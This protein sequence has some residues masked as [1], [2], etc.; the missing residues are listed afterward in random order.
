MQSYFLAR[1]YAIIFPIVALVVGVT[2]VLSFIAY[3]LMKS[4][5]KTA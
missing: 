1:E 4:K 3:V 5:K 2:G